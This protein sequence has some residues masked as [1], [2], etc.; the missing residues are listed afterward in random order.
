MMTSLNSGR[1][2]PQFGFGLR[3]IDWPAWTRAMT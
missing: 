2:P 1:S 3:V